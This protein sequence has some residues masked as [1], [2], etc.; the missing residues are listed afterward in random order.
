MLID[1]RHF[2]Q[3]GYSHQPFSEGLYHGHVQHWHFKNINLTQAAIAYH[4]YLSLYSPIHTARSTPGVQD[5]VQHPE[6][7]TH[8]DLSP[9][10]IYPGHILS[11]RQRPQQMGETIVEKST[12]HHG[13]GNSN[14][15]PTTDP[16]LVYP[17]AVCLLHTCCSISPPLRSTVLTRNK[18]YLSTS[19]HRI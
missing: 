8:A 12:D 13:R 1:A 16:N 18:P 9:P 10:Q 6:T 3:I 4:V 14:S 2:S 15:G 19:C 11:R 17:P 7:R 5:C